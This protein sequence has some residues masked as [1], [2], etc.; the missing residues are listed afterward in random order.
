[1]FE[2]SDAMPL[3]GYLS[4]LEALNSFGILFAFIKLKSPEGGY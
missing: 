1:M 4:L 3:E 2:V